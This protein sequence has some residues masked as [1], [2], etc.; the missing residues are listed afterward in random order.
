MLHH[1]EGTPSSYSGIYFSPPSAISCSSMGDWQREQETKSAVDWFDCSPESSEQQCVS[2]VSAL[3]SNGPNYG[4]FIDTQEELF[5]SLF[6][7]CCFI[8]RLANLLLVR[9]RLLP[10][11]TWTILHSPLEKGL[12]LVAFPLFCGSR[13]VLS[14]VG[15]GGS[16]V[17]TLGFG[18]VAS[19]FH[20]PAVLL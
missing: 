14:L 15:A 19:I 17:P 4:L 10:P 12:G 6:H 20:R 18:A 5:P 1:F 16:V 9:H 7:R 8:M 2:A 13:V 11:L 3:N